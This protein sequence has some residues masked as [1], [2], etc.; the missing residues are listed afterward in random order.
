LRARGKLLVCLAAGAAGLLAAELW[1]RQIDRR[2]APPPQVGALPMQPSSDPR[3]RFEHRP[4]ATLLVR[5]L[6]KDGRL[7][8]EVL[9]V[10]NE[11]GYRGPRVEKKKPPGTYRIVVLGDSQTF[12]YGIEQEEAWPAVLEKSLLATPSGARVEV[13]NCAVGSYDT[14]QEAASLEH[15]LSWEPDV[16]LL[17]YFVNDAALPAAA[18]GPD[19]RPVEV[20]E[21]GFWM[22]RLKPGRPG[23]LGWLRRRSRLVDFLADAEYRRLVLRAWERGA[24]DLYRDDSEPWARVR[25]GLTRAS[26]LCRGARIRFAV[27]LVPFLAPAGDGLLSTAAYRK[28][29][30][31]CHVQGIACDDLEPSFRG[32]DIAAL[33][34]HERDW[35]SGAEAHRIEGLAVAD[36]IRG[37]GFLPAPSGH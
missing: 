27:I 37:Q 29:S 11:D 1:A 19:A 34:V 12:G 28:V 7:Q 20:D 16:V 17:G 13:M 26:E 15:W 14:E 22:L 6:D 25:S 5:Y 36:W 18:P 23:F 9:S 33:R 24:S 35:H 8:R 3:L 31:Y 2:R 32:R 21:E 30:E 10:I 4:G